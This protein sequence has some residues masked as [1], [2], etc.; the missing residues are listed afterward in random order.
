MSARP[1]GILSSALRQAFGVVLV[2]CLPFTLVAGTGSPLPTVADLLV[3]GL[4]PGERFGASVATAGDVNGDGYSD[5][6]VGMPDHDNG[7]NTD[8]GRV[9]V[10][11]GSASGLTGTVAWVMMGTMA[12]ARFGHSVST[13]GDVN[14]DGFSD[15]II[16]APGHGGQGAVFVYHGSATGLQLTVAWSVLGGEAGCGFGTSVALAGDVNNDLVSD[17]LVGAPLANEL[18]TDRGKVYCY[19]GALGTGL[20]AAPLWTWSGSQNS[21]QFGSSVAGAGDLNGDGRSDIVIGEP[22][23]DASLTD[24]GRITVFHGNGSGLSLSVTRDGP[25]S[26]AHFGYV[27]SSAGDMNGDG[28]SDLLVGAPGYST[29][30]GR[31]YGYRGGAAAIEATA[32]SIFNGT[33][34]AARLGSSVSLAG[35]VNADGYA[36]VVVGAPLHD[37]GFADGGQALVFIGGA[38][39]G[40]HFGTVYRTYNGAQVNAQLGFAV[41]T[42]GDVNGDGVSDLLLGMPEQGGVGRIG[43]YEGGADVLTAP[44]LPAWSQE[45]DV[46]NAYMGSSVDQ[47]GD[48]N[49]DGF[50]DVIVGVPGM[51][52]VRVYMGSPTGLLNTY[53]SATGSA[54]DEEFGFCVSS[55]GDV[56]GDGYSDVIIGGYAHDGFRGRAYVYLGSPTGLGATYHWRVTGAVAA[57]R[58]G[59]SVSSAGDVNGDGYSDIIVGAYQENG[60]GAVYGYFGSA[61]GLSTTASWTVAGAQL[62]ADYGSVVTGGGDVDADGYDD[63]L[64]GAQRH[65]HAG[66]GQCGAV[67]LFRGTSAGILTTPSWVQYGDKAGGEFGYDISFAGDVNGDGFSDVIIGAY[68]YNNGEA[69]EGRS[70]VYHGSLSGLG[71]APTWQVES[72]FPGAYWGSS[73]AGAGD[74][75]GDGYSDVIVGGYRFAQAYL[76]EGRASVYHGSATGLSTSA[77]WTALGGAVNRNL[78]YSL[79][80]A[81]DV[82]GDGYGDVII[83]VTGYSSG[84]SLEGYCAVYMGNLQRS[85]QARTRQYRSDLVTP[86]QTSNG[87]FQSDCSWGIGQDVWSTMGR[88]RVKLVWEYKGHGPPFQGAPFSNWTGSTGEDAGWT[89]TGLLGSELKRVLSTVLGSSSH[90]AWRTRVRHHPATLLD[91]RVFGR[92]FYHGLHDDQVP[93][94]KTEFGT[95]GLLPV[96][97]L[98]QRTTCVGGSVRFEWTTAT[99]RNCD[100]FIVERS[101]DALTWEAIGAVDCDGNSQA[102]RDYSFHDQVNALGT[103]YFRLKQFDEDGSMQQLPVVSA[104]PCGAAGSFIHVWPSPVAD[105]LNLDVARHSGHLEG[106]LRVVLYDATGRSVRSR[107]FS[108]DQIISI[109]I[110]ELSI[111]TYML[112]VSS[113]EG[114]MVGC[115][116]VVKG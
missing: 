15:I 71:A 58:F 14:G 77:T 40:S 67:Y 49:G 33:Q 65:D 50:A 113:V 62:N 83:G 45:P 72:D 75:N 76:G 102:P 88:A 5:I 79:G 46:A 64:V 97:L 80:G 25:S 37:G 1:V 7:A 114:S 47:A 27:V 91:G 29:G 70:Y 116:R 18:G 53:W 56:N 115:S 107:L 21:A 16:G 12:N 68:Q 95:C 99:E 26:N 44:T 38:I 10:F 69:S 55:A 48:V 6:I 105:I 78:G 92:W 104:L 39:V 43:A 108:S 84:Q 61:T 28:Y 100:G 2:A 109:D 59:G 23:Y 112:V 13:A 93:S 60:M 54:T 101:W 20:V 66:L 36:D 73:A 41:H 89:D 96:E 111:G 94:V 32:T 34:A 52:Q 103:R 31:L 9:M 90:P 42:C 85:R 87:T 4:Q 98:D 74:V 106:G 3:D 24:R 11:H 63:V 30:R 51:N 86:V 57:G 22:Y 17:V 81:G 8:A 35:D 110:S 19:R 82:N